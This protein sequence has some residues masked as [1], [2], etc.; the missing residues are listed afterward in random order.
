MSLKKIPST[1]RYRRSAPA[2]CT[3]LDGTCPSANCSGITAGH[4]SGSRAA[5]G[6][7]DVEPHGRRSRW[8]APSALDAR[9]S[10]S[11]AATPRSYAGGTGAVT[12]LADAGGH[13]QTER[14]CSST[15]SASSTSCSSSTPHTSY[16]DVATTIAEWV[17]SF[18]PRRCGR[19]ERDSSDTRWIVQ[20]GPR[21]IDAGATAHRRRSLAVDE[22]FHWF[23]HGE[24]IAG[25]RGTVSRTGYTGEDGAAPCRT[26]TAWQPSSNG[27]AALQ[28]H[29]R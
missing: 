20:C 5:S 17:S 21:A 10:A 25:V 28:H 6:C 8:P 26:I 29:W 14:P 23:A 4:V 15:A 27:T 2:W 7:S 9:C 22:V 12:G 19:G 18:Q 11:P 1:R 16:K 13:V 24:I 3:L